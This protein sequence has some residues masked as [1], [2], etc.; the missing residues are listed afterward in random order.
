MPTTPFWGPA[1]DDNFLLPGA[2]ASSTFFRLAAGDPTNVMDFSR[3]WMLPA[4]DNMVH[5]ENVLWRGHHYWVDFRTTLGLRESAKGQL[6]TLTIPRAS[7]VIDG[8]LF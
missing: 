4:S 1:G 5:F 7:I 8:S 2:G 6:S 3:A